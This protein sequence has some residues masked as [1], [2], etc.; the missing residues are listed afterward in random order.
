MGLLA[1]KE[2]SENIFLGCGQKDL[3]KLRSLGRLLGLPVAALTYKQTNR[4]RK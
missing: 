1:C 2:K 4:K 3:D